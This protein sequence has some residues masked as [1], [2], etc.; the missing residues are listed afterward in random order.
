MT[1]QNRNDKTDKS[2]SDTK[3]TRRKA[4]KTIAGGIT[5]LAAY[6]YLPAKWEKPIMESIFIPAHAQTSAVDPTD[7][8]DPTDPGNPGPDPQPPIEPSS[9]I[10]PVEPPSPP[11]MCDWNVDILVRRGSSGQFEETPSGSTI[12]RSSYTYFITTIASVGP[13]AGVPIANE[14]FHIWVI[15]NGVLLGGGAT[16][17]N[18]D[19][20]GEFQFTLNIGSLGSGE[21]R[22]VIVKAVNAPY[23][24]A[25]EGWNGTLA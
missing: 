8:T 10:E 22:R 13:N 11:F 18:S 15:D 9:P 1:A 5:A 17:I 6:Q 12:V 3:I 16:V 23:N 24:C 7:P 2:N 14:R 4:V 20:N 19:S 25:F 21:T